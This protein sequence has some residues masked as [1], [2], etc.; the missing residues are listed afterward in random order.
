M[1]DWMKRDQGTFRPNKKVGPESRNYRL[2]QLS[3]AT[4]GAGDLKTAVKLPEGENLNDWLAMNVVEFYNQI[5]C[6]YSPIVEHCT[7]TSCPEMSAGPGFKYAWQD[8]KKFKKPT[9]LPAPEYISNLMQWA[10][11]I[12]DDEK[13]FPS[14]PSVPFPKDFR[15]QVS[16]IFTRLFRIYGHIYHHHLDDVKTVGAEAHLNT[17]FRHFI[18][19]SKEFD[20]IPEDQLAPLKDLINQLA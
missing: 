13:I 20:L 7:P 6:L 9:E 14:D 2:Q 1:F 16:K 11:S 5:N 12:I 4:L 10:E 18:L 15:A 8:G 17:S 3:Q 19:F